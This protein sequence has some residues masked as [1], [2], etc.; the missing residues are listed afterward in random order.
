[1]KRL[2]F[3]SCLVFVSVNILAYQPILVDGR[4]WTIVI[5]GEDSSGGDNK[6]EDFIYYKS[7]GDS[8]INSEAYKKIYKSSNKIDWI[9]D[10][11][12]IENTEEEKVWKYYN[13]NK[14]LIFDFALNVGDK[15][16]N[17]SHIC[18]EIK[19][20]KD[21]K[22]NILKRMYFEEYCWIEKCGYEYIILD[23]V[24]YYLLS[25]E[26]ENG[27]IFDCSEGLEYYN[28]M[29]VEGYSWNVVSSYCPIFPDV[30]TY[31]TRKQKI[32]GDSIINGISY[33]KLWEY[34][35]ANLDKCYLLALIREDIEEQKIFA[36]NK[37]AEVLLYDLGVE[38]GDTVKVWNYLSALENFDS[39]E[40]FDSINVE[41]GPFSILVVDNIELIEDQI[42]GTLKKIS[43]HKA[44]KEFFTATIYERYGSTTGWSHNNHAELIGSANYSMICAFDENDELV[45]KREYTIAGYGEVKDCY[46][47]EEIGTNIETAQK[48]ECIYYNSQEKRLY[49]DFDG[50]ES[51]AIYDAMGKRVM[52]KEIDSATKSIPL[53]LKLGIYIVTNKNQNIYSKIVVK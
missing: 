16:K 46:I 4:I 28:P 25:V 27:I 6:L 26:D 41:Y 1:M 24:S 49:I 38:V 43:Y 35:D 7:I 21:K 8:I 37:V 39:I 52:V 10:C 5:S 50:D 18:R 40:D 44:E 30:T 42:Y 29:V 47:K 14:D 12:M 32:E 11:L 22:G 53:N 20:V 51:L 13:N 19:Y 33:K 34:F 31:N 9:L 17:S 15:F 23:G 48:E 3:F 2:L 36:Y 45:L